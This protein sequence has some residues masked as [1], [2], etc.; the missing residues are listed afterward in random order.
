MAELAERRLCEEPNPRSYQTFL[1]EKTLAM[2]TIVCLE[3]GCGK[4]M[5]AVLL[6]RSLSHLFRKPEKGICVFL[7]PTVS[8]CEQQAEV[9]ERYTDLYVGTYVGG[10]STMDVH[11]WTT[12]LQKQ[13]VFVM[14]PAILL[15]NL[16]HR[17]FNPDHVELLIFDECHHCAKGH[18]YANIM[19][20]FY[21]KPEAK[22]PRILGMTAS[23]IVGKGKTW[24]GPQAFKESFDC[25]ETMLRSK[26]ITFADKEL[27]SFLPSSDMKIKEHLPDTKGKHRTTDIDNR[28]ENLTR[29]FRLP[30][31]R[32][33]VNKIYNTLNYCLFE[34][35]LFSAR[36]AAEIMLAGC[37]GKGRDAEAAFLRRVLNILEEKA[38]LDGTA[39]DQIRAI[40]SKV[41]LLLDVLDEYKSAQDL[42]CIVFV[43]RVIAAKVLTLLLNSRPYVRAQCVASHRNK[44]KGLTLAT[45]RNSLEDFRAGKA[46][47]IVATNVA[48]EGLDIQSCSLVIRFNMPKTERS[49]IQSRGRARKQ[50]SD[51]VI[52]MES[53]N[54]NEEKLLHAILE[55]EKLMHE[56]LHTVQDTYDHQLFYRQ[57]DAYHVESTGAVVNID[58]SVSLLHQYCSTLGNDAHPN[59]QFYKGEDG[60]TTCN[61]T[62]PDICTVKYI[63]GKRCA[64]EEIAR[65]AACLEACRKLHMAGAL[66][67]NLRPVR[68]T[69]ISKSVS[70]TSDDMDMYETIIPDVLQG[71][72]GVFSENLTF[73]T[74][75]LSFSS[76]DDRLSYRNFAL[77]LSSKLDASVEVER[78]ELNLG[79]G[80]NVVVQLGSVQNIILDSDNIAAVNRFYEI[81][82]PILWQRR[83][84]PIH[85]QQYLL[86]PLLPGKIDVDWK[87]VQS[88]TPPSIVSDNDDKSVLHFANYSLRATDI[89]GGLILTKHTNEPVFYSLLGVLKETT[90]QSPFSNPKYITYSDYFLK[91]HNMKLQY[92]AQPLL[93][94]KMLGDVQNYLLPRSTDMPGRSHRKSTIELPPE[95]CILLEPE[96][97]YSV[98]A[99]VMVLPSVIYRLECL[100]SAAQLTK[101]VGIHMST[102]MMLMALTSASCNEGFSLERL[103]FL[104]DSFLKFALSLHLVSEYPEQQEGFLS[105]KRQ[106]QISNSNL[107]RLGVQR[108]L[109][110]YM[111]DGQFEPKDWIAPV[112]CSS[113]ASHE[114]L[115]GRKLCDKGHRWLRR[116]SVADVMEAIIGAY[117]TE[118]SADAAYHFM[119]WAGFKLVDRCLVPVFSCQAS[120]V[121]DICNLE[122]IIGYTFRNKCFLV[123]A[124]THASSSVRSYQR[125]EYLGDAVLD[126][127]IV[128]HLYASYPSLQPGLLN[129]L[130]VAT[131][132]NVW[133]AF[134]AVRHNFHKYL[135]HKLK[136]I[137]EY[138]LNKNVQCFEDWQLE[139]PPKCLSDLV[140]SLAGALLFDTGGNL[141]LVWSVLEP[142]LRPVASPET[143][144]L[145]PVRELQELCQL[146]EI[147]AP[148]YNVGTCSVTLADGGIVT[149]QGSGGANKKL[150]KNQ[151]SADALGKLKALGFQHPRHELLHAIRAETHIE[152][153]TVIIN[154]GL[155]FSVPVV[156][157][158]MESELASF[159]P[160]MSS[161]SSSTES[162][163]F[164]QQSLPDHD[165]PSDLELVDTEHESDVLAASLAE[166]FGLDDDLL[167]KLCSATAS[168]TVPPRHEG[169]GSDSFVAGA[170]RA[171]LQILCQKRRW[172]DPEY[173]ICEESGPPHKKHFALAVTIS[174]PIDGPVTFYGE[175]QRD[176]K[177]AKDSAANAAIAYLKKLLS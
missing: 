127:L 51:Y 16:R 14:T 107:H 135:R 22:C 124:F 123:E 19:S 39:D 26:I 57:K 165:L 117:I 142:L 34:L 126:Y 80:R 149:G 85:L 136:E 30:E 84:P 56:Q 60:G 152:A 122:K 125:L 144:A 173:I 163:L 170:P 48:E 157:Q 32:Q 153:S 83:L 27:T 63:K 92:P 146:K 71:K 100:S 131:V 175:P 54:L 177:R 96:L 169:G 86:L 75:V 1:F 69:N 74:Y 62:L 171:E 38:I 110:T 161:S 3:T 52:L 47:V 89:K 6:I 138:L 40:S 113:L 155:N 168:S 18:P 98:V 8:L 77:F 58:S 172:S 73:H 68:A 23:P 94:V 43:E 12:H 50:G 87:C 21:H 134:V 36:K 97:D 103:E 25:L 133:F 11:W 81:V 151:S 70:I 174:L 99:S 101:L 33:A 37:D 145:H 59:F 102:T 121:D 176:M 46:N 90:A 130:K 4:T 139:Q 49:S 160:P 55:G 7:A 143:L 91:R 78:F 120:E 41:Q 88:L 166:E 82:F 61:V 167:E 141:E 148:S 10:T 116:K 112:P 158:C 118:N 109:V 45:Q 9:I 147:S 115:L 106:E 111:R 95:L 17:F 93:K 154:N 64:T 66:S 65:K 20:E 13:E 159:V 42:R 164:R 24:S 132:N 140:E 28:F 5:I 156:T 44:L 108:G 114:K 162:D 15:D 2:N 105:Q 79:R 29:E 137:D 72:L 104:G 150:L 128:L 53:G 31:E 129:D 67:D 119:T 76:S 35:G